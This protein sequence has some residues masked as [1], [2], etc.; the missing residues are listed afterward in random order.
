[1][2]ANSL[3]LRRHTQSLPSWS[4]HSDTESENK[5]GYLPG[6]SECVTLPGNRVYADVISLK[7]GPTGLRWV[8]NPAISILVRRPCEDTERHRENE[9]M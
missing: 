4:L 3:Y 1:M 2:P 8:L 6:T 5:K 9:C 7:R